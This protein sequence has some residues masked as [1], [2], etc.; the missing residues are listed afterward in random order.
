MTFYTFITNHVY[1]NSTSAQSRDALF[2]NTGAG[3]IL[4]DIYTLKLA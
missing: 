1:A 4:Y 3:Y 2:I